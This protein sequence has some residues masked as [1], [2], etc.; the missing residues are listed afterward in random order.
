MCLL[1]I[2]DLIFARLLARIIRLRA[3]FFDH[4]IKIIHLDNASEITSQIFHDYCISLGINIEHHV[5]HVHTQ[6]DLVESF[7]RHL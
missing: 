6:N 4:T 5:T 2:H 7:I 1:S 3:Q